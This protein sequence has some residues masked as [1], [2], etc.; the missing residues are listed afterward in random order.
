[1]FRWL[2]R[3]LGFEKKDAPAP[4]VE[5]APAD[6]P[7][8]SPAPRRPGAAL[9]VE[10]TAVGAPAP[11]I[12]KPRIVLAGNGPNRAPWRAVK[13]A[14]ALDPVIVQR[15]LKDRLRAL[16]EDARHRAD[17]R[18]IERLLQQVDSDQLD[19]PPFPDVAQELDELLKQTTTDIL[20]IARVV[21]RDPGMVRRVWT[22]A[23]SAMYSSAPRSLHHAVA[24][25]G[26]DALWRIG[27]SVCLN[28]T[29]F[30]VEG[31][32]TAAESVRHHGIATAEVAAMLGGE[33]RGSLYLAGLLH[34]IGELI[35]LQVAA[36]KKE[37]PPSHDSVR[38]VSDEV[39]AALGVLMVH[40]WKLDDTVVV[41]VGHCA[42]PSAAPADTQRIAR[43][44]RA[45]SI[46]A[47]ASRLAREGITLESADPVSEIQELGFDPMKALS[48]ADAVY[49]ELYETAGPP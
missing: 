27:M 30:R 38:M 24:R 47:H 31:M 34:G 37:R 16:A 36:D 15:Y 28:D 5:P 9:P 4:A 19:L 11:V 33:R 49:N 46:A 26:L 43:I 21:E 17:K 12:Q 2:L 41:G 44:V 8:S 18:F 48:R 35:V 20:Q 3:L 10:P 13:P 32:Q 45:A 42:K 22:H 7:S 39:G 1:M 14:P 40:S 25:V 23:R 29:V 6:A